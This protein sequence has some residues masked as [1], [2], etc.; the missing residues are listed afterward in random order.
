MPIARLSFCL[1]FLLA[2][3]F[4]Q[5]TTQIMLQN[6]QATMAAQ[7]ASDD[8][9]RAAQQA[10][11][12]AAQA[13]Q[14]A[15]QDAQLP[16]RQY[17]YVAKPKFSIKPGTYSSPLS[18]KI[19]D[20]TRGA[21]IYYTTDGW[22]PT[23]ASARY[24]G[25]I[26]INS[27][28]T[29]QAV[30]VSPQLYRS[31]ITSAVYTMKVA[32][33]SATPNATPLCANPTPYSTTDSKIMLPQGT[34]VRLLF[35]SD[36][37]SKTAEV[38]DKIAFTLA[39]DLKASNEIVIPKG[40]PAVGT[41][42]EADKARALGIPGLIH[43]QVQALNASGIAVKLRGIAAKEGRD[44]AGTALALS[45]AVPMGLLE[46]GE[47]AEIKQGTPFTAFVDVDT[48]LPPSN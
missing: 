47:E 42:T 25:P 6:Q 3:A 34:P 22:T 12:A 48:T 14:Q 36:I 9:M 1:P 29:L 13:S 43:F 30:A 19:K 23:T 32:G 15:A 28:T 31:R 7:Q 2:S 20:A 41:V 4:V 45:I 10:N 5:D 24:T 40:T 39:D 35:A 37:N 38:G 16:S 27:T 26:E 21:T 18:V 33:S 17:D 11:A 46:H 8:A 44:K